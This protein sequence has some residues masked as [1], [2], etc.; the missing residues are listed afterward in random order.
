MGVL[1]AGAYVIKGGR[2]PFDQLI[3]TVK[4]AKEQVEASDI[5][6]EVHEGDGLFIEGH[7]HDR[8]GELLIRLEEAGEQLEEIWYLVLEALEVVD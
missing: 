4:W 3:E 8:K 1:T 5:P 6:V 7:L 2:I